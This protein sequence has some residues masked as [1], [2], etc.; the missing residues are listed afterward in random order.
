LQH[1]LLE[2]LAYV[3]GR[4]PHFIDRVVDLVAGRLAAVPD[5]LHCFVDLFPNALERTL[6]L[7]AYEHEKKRDGNE[8][9]LKTFARH[10]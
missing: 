9:D 3:V 8:T 10:D 4:I 2:I 5:V 7:T 1:A 6:L